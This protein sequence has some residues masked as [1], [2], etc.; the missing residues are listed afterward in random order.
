MKK[1]NTHYESVHIDY[2]RYSDELF[3]IVVGTFFYHDKI[4]E[5]F[6]PR[7]DKQLPHNISSIAIKY[8]LKRD[9][10]ITYNHDSATYH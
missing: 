3:K 9:F 1:L 7:T 6:L 8:R 5:F 4:A 2:Y 10:G